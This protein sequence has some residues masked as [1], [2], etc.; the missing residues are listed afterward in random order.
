M[1]E[2]CPIC[3]RY[4]LARDY[5]PKPCSICEEEQLELLGKNSIPP[6]R[7][8]KPRQPSEPRTHA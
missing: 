6:Y 8:A 2:I 7:P 4:S 1:F 5:P 3:G